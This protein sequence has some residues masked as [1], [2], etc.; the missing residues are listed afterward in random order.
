M[1]WHAGPVSSARHVAI[2]AGWLYRRLLCAA[3]PLHGAGLRAARR[4]SRSLP[5]PAGGSHDGSIR[6]WWRGTG[7]LCTDLMHALARP[8]SSPKSGAD[9]IYCAALPGS[10]LAS[11]SRCGMVTGAPPG[12]RCSKFF[13]RSSARACGRIRRARR[14]RWPDSHRP[15]PSRQHPR[16]AVTGE[17][18]PAGALRFSG[19]LTRWIGCHRQWSP[20]E[21]GLRSTSRLGRWSRL[22]RQSPWGT[23]RRLEARCRTP[24]WRRCRRPGWMSC[25]CSPP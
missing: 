13:A 9:G 1:K 8:S 17:L 14:R 21:L 12:W 2:G 22:P 16:S 10:A 6:S 24:V 4:R 18:L 20:H 3:A 23:R 15:L 7:R 25:C 5:R 11:R 19:W